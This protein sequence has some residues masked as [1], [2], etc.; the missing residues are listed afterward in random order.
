[1]VDTNPSKSAPLG[2]AHRTLTFELVLFSI[3]NSL[4]LLML[5]HYS[6]RRPKHEIFELFT[7]IECRSP[8]G[9]ALRIELFGL[10]SSA[11]N[12]QGLTQI[13]QE[14]IHNCLKKHDSSYVNFRYFGLE[15]NARPSLKWEVKAY[16]RKIMH[17]FSSALIAVNLNKMKALDIGF[18][19]I[20]QKI[21][22]SEMTNEE[23]KLL[24]R[25]QEES[26]R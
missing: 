7:E 10:V 6:I 21:L 22:M 15:K 9:D 23:K 26:V 16:E 4:R 11:G 14:E 8:Q 12:L 1:M 3:E 2:G 18:S 19:D 13:S 5:L 17:C 25:L 20:M 24:E